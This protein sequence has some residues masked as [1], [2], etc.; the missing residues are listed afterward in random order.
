[1]RYPQC[2]SPISNALYIGI[3]ALS[4]EV[5]EDTTNCLT[6]VSIGC[7][8]RLMIT[9]SPT[10]SDWQSVTIELAV[11]QDGLK[12]FLHNSF[13]IEYQDARCPLYVARKL[14]AECVF[15]SHSPPTSR[16]YIV[17]RQQCARTLQLFCHR[18]RQID[19]GESRGQVFD[20]GLDQR[21]CPLD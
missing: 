16:K 4:S 9:I 15:S 21:I 18:E 17:K 14:F 12:T 3:L 7:P 5:S 11:R 10:A 6:L 2:T 13:R 20:P 19:K 8:V 1:M